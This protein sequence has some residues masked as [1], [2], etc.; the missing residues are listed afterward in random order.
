M[1]N[2][3]EN[4]DDLMDKIVREILAEQENGE[5]PNVLTKAREL[6]IHKDRIYRRLKDVESRTTRKLVNCKLSTVTRGLSFTI[7]SLFY[8][9]FSL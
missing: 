3:D 2:S 7:Y 9:I 8:D 4:I 6:S 1:S 5:R